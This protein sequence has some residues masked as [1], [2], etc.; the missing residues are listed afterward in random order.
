M[1]LSETNKKTMA[2]VLC[3]GVVARAA[4]VKRQKKQTLTE[5]MICKGVELD[6][7]RGC[8][9]CQEQQ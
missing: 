6:V 2:L 3:S 1:E 7:V 4:P 8:V 5:K 9:K